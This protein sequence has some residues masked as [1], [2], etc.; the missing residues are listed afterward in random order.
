MPFISRYSVQLTKST[1][2]LQVPGERGR[3]QA[4][5]IRSRQTKTNPGENAI[6]AAT[7]VDYSR[8]FSP[9]YRKNVSQ[10]HHICKIIL[11]ANSFF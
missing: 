5:K 9:K 6:L 8:D 2:E 4:T 3:A 11:T 7:P 1:I 10:L